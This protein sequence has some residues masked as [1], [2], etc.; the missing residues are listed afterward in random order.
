MWPKARVDV[1]VRPSGDIWSAEYDETGVAGL[2]DRL[3][4]LGATA[5][6]LEATG[7][8]EVPLASALAAANVKRKGLGRP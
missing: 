1:A 2:V 7:G 3:Q 8:L 6:V 4:A 5:V